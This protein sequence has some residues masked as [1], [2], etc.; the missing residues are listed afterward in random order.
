D[1]AEFKNIK[2]W[3]GRHEDFRAEKLLLEILTDSTLSDISRDRA[4]L[5]LCEITTLDTAADRAE[6]WQ[7]GEPIL[8]RHAMR[9]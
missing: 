7:S 9:M 5:L 4:S 6:W 2:N 3:M 1:D 8:M